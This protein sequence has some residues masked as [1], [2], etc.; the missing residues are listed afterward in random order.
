LRNIRANHWYEL[1]TELPNIGVLS[2][3]LTVKVHEGLVRGDKRA[4]SRLLIHVT[5]ISEEYGGEASNATSSQALR[6]EG[7]KIHVFGD[8]ATSRWRLLQSPTARPKHLGHLLAL[9]RE[10]KVVR[11]GATSPRASAAFRTYTLVMA[12]PGVLQTSPLTASSSTCLLSTLSKSS[13][14]L[15]V[16]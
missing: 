1:L 4:R 3:P 14:A 12:S 16:Q 7:Q 6:D 8:V 5:M 10:K 15:D 11:K 2:A 13:R 9:F